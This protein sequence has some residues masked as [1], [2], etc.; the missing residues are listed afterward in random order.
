MA[1]GNCGVRVLCPTRWT[2]RADTMHS[3]TCIRNYTVLQQLWDQAANIDHDT[4]VIARIGPAQ[5]ELF[6][7]FLRL[8]LGKTLLCNTDNLSR[9]LQKNQPT[10]IAKAVRFLQK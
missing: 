9:T 3:I 2:V 8:V 1:P 5:M 10:Y 6:D 4:E 7:F